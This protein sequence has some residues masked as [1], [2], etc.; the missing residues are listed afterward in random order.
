[1]QRV[2]VLVEVP[3]LLH[4]M[5]VD[6]DPVIRSAGLHPGQLADIDGIISFD[7][8]SELIV[9]C[10]AASGRDDFDLL[11]GASGRSEHL[12]VLGRYMACGPT[13][14]STLD[15]LLSNHP[16]YVRG[17]GAYLLDL[18]NGDLLAGYRTH[19]PG[20]RGA[21]YIARGATAFGYAV[22]KEVSGV[23]PKAVLMSLPEPA[24]LEAYEAVFASTPVSFNAPHFG[25]VFSRS[26]L[27][28]ANLK[29]DPEL[30]RMLADAIAARWALH[31]PDVRERV[32]R[33]LV[34]SVF[35]G[36]HSLESTARRIGM[37]PEALSRELKE[38]GCSFRDL[39]TEAKLEMAGQFLTDARMSIAEVAQVLGYSEISAFTR[40][41]TSGR[42][43]APA[44]WRRKRN[45]GRPPPLP[46]LPGRAVPTGAPGE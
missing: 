23:V 12:G 34:P 16:R 42:G 39:F 27:R 46:P 36:T 13:F 29:A 20:I 21:S 31:Q 7:H 15:D 22:F 24:S 17:A 33:A 44:Q 45:A 18:G 9:H 3:R 10:V 4:G 2:G 14:G 19:Q 6:P 8:F 35:S 38:L 30:R 26:S 28:T 11:V 5:G 41:F 37:A 32:L 1:M 25:L 40:F 43:V